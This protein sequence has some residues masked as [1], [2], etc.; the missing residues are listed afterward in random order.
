M[1]HRP[2]NVV[3]F[4]SDQEQAQVCRPD[5]PCRTPVADR[6]AAEGLRFE[7][8]YTPTAHSCPSRASYFTGLHPCHHGIHNNILTHTAIDGRVAAGC[9]MFS[10]SLRDAGWNLGIAG[11]WHTSRFEY[12]QDRGWEDVGATAIPREARTPPEFWKFLEE[13][14]R[15]PD[16]AGPRRRGEILVP[17]YRRRFLYGT[18]EHGFEEEEDYAMVRGAI[19]AMERYAKEDRPFFLHCGPISPHDPYI[20]PEK[21]ARMYDP[22]AV[23]LPVSYRDNLKDKPR[24]YQRQRNHLWSQLSE[25]EVRESIAHYWGYCSMV[26]DLRAMVVDAID[27][28]GLR[29]N[30]ILILTSDHGDY[31]GAHG[32]YCKGAPAFDEA[33][34]IPLIIRWPEGIE[35]PGRVVDEFVTLSDLSPT[36]LEV[37]DRPPHPSSGASLVPFFRAECPADWTDEFHGQFNGVEFYYTQRIVQTRRF[38]YVFNA[39]DFDEL[40]DLE[41]DPHELVNLAADEDR[42]DVLEDMVRRMWR[43][44]HREK[45]IIGNAYFTVALAPLGPYSVMDGW[46]EPRPV[47]RETASAGRP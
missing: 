14:A 18:A 43:F 2:P 40:Y 24:L 34:R 4:M 46:T 25:E 20:V 5:H 31:C 29:D 13:D 19:R 47:D 33:Y 7:R 39:F 38:K 15:R 10:E 1:P 22:D 9:R 44:S 23:E 17:G 35:K 12:P 32:L 8:A 27:R 11:K 42:R 41:S 36:F 26:D 16:P 3:V 21:Y 6:V 28:L 30:T 45:D 37:A